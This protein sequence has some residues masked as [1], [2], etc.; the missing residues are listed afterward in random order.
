[1]QRDEDL[2]PRGVDP[3]FPDGHPIHEAPDGTLVLPPPDVNLGRGLDD[4]L[5]TDP[6]ATAKFA[7]ARFGGKDGALYGPGSGGL[8]TPG[9][10][11]GAPPL[12]GPW[13]TTFP[14]PNGANVAAPGTLP[15]EGNV[16][17]PSPAAP[18]TG[19]PGEGYNG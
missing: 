16:P 3:S 14:D 15:V 11:N 17:Q 18:S 13:A 10:G 4:Q 8:G 9:T 2:L 19:F 1:M 6:R 5:T 12:Q 7:G